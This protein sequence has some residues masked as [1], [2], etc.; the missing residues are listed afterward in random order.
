MA[1]TLLA[2]IGALTGCS[3]YPETPEDV[4]KEAYSRMSKMDYEGLKELFS[5][6]ANFPTE[7][8]F[9]ELV[10]DELDFA[11]TYQYY[12]ATNV[13]IEGDTAIVVGTVHL[14]DGTE[15]DAVYLVKED[16]L[17]KIYE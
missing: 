14:T 9:R 12:E 15:S 6:N 10:E 8:E 2:S 13:E 3:S 7:E 16:G 4:V 5:S 11:N 17:W 1:I